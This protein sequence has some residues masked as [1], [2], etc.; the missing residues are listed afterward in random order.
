MARSRKGRPIHGWLILDKPE[1]WT[2]TRAVGRVRHLLGAAKAGHG[3]T[4]DPLAT[5]VLPI[6]LGEATKAIPFVMGA[7]KHYRFHVR[8]G[9]ERDTDDS[10][11]RVVQ[12]SDARPSAEDIGALVPRF[13]GRVAQVPPA[14]SA[15]KVDGQ[16]AYALAREGAPA[17]LAARDVV[18]DR[19]ELVEIVEDRAVAVFEIACGKGTY[20]RALARDMGRLL[21]CFGHV[22]WLR[23]TAVG[24]VTQAQ[25][26]SLDKLE[27]LVHSPPLNGFL[28]PVE[29]AL[30]DIPAL[31]VTGGEADRLRSGQTVRVPSSKHGT[32]YVMA[33]GQLVALAELSDG[34][35]RPFRVFRL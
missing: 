12:S 30:D 23:R 22:C 25:A 5:G 18:I 11:G 17:T 27:H 31:A 8:W 26:I 10:Q 19:L 29:T 7:K 24:G 3:G 4:L 21:G 6:A 9:E 32:V 14:F 13:T 16:R 33:H 28:L 1:G 2:S 15:V 34:E 35:L 20:V